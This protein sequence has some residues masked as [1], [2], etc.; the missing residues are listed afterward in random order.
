MTTTNPETGSYGT[1]MPPPARRN[2]NLG[3]ASHQLLRGLCAVAVVLIKVV[4]IVIA[5]HTQKERDCLSPSQQQQRALLSTT[6]TPQTDNN[7]TQNAAEVGGEL[8]GKM[9][10]RGRGF[11]Q[12]RNLKCCLDSDLPACAL[13]LLLLGTPFLF[14]CLSP[15]ISHPSFFAA[16]ETLFR[17][18]L[19][20]FLLLSDVAGVSTLF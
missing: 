14:G 20:S 1:H 18:A 17:R 10:E 2:S 19:L 4:E 6:T 5:L 12:L 9:S 8:I 16:G 3:L 13:L 11:V 7:G 15:N